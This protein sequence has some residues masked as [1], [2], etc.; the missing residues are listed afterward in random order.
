MRRLLGP[1]SPANQPQP[2][3]PGPD[4]ILSGAETTMPARETE[5]DGDFA[6]ASCL[7]CG[8]A[9]I[10][11]DQRRDPLFVGRGSGRRRGTTS[12]GRLSSAQNPMAC[13]NVAGIESDR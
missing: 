2:G 7:V 5:S 13:A 6:R 1:G 10:T 4:I 12:G 3:F 11:V 9:L 8:F